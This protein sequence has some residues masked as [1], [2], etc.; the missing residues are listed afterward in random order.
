MLISDSGGGASGSSTRTV[1]RGP[2]S[3]EVCE[4]FGP[5]P[6]AA[7]IHEKRETVGLD[8]DALAMIAGEED[9]KGYALDITGSRYLRRADAEEGTEVETFMPGRIAEPLYRPV[10]D[11]RVGRVEAHQ[12]YGA[13]GRVGGKMQIDRAARRRVPGK[14]IADYRHG[15]VDDAFLHDRETFSQRLLQTAE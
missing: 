8:E 3:V 10:H 14:C 2:P 12:A 13:H 6:Q 1:T 11:P 7:V 5:E 9:L 4:S 15:V